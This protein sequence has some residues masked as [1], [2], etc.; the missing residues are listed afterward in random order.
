M[1]W[2]FSSYFLTIYRVND[3]WLVI[4]PWLTKLQAAALSVNVLLSTFKG[5]KVNCVGPAVILSVLLAMLRNFTCPSLLAGNFGRVF[6]K[7]QG[8]M[9]AICVCGSCPCGTFVSTCEF[10][11]RQSRSGAAQQRQTPE[12]RVASPQSSSSMN[13]GNTHTFVF[14]TLYQMSRIQSNII[15]AKRKN[16][17]KKLWYC[18]NKAV[19]LE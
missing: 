8:F 10:S 16:K 2:A 18:R 13:C 7:R 5:S 17:K 3:Q 11:S 9:W 1:G 19:I 15:T 12:Q 14:S 4:N 6:Y